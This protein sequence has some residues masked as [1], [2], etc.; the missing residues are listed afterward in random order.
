MNK[1]IRKAFTLIELLVVIAIIGIL[2]GLIVVSMSG[3]TQKANIAKAQVFSSSLRNALMMD[4]VS[5]WK[6][7]GGTIEGT[8]T[9]GDVLDSWSNNNAI[10]V[11]GVPIIKGG[12]DCVSG[13]CIQFNGSTDSIDFGNKAVF[14]MGIKDHTIS[15]WVKFNNNLALQDE[16]LIKTGGGGG[17]AGYW[18]RRP[19]G[20]SALNVG[21]NDGSGEI[22]GYI[23]NSGGLI[24]NSWYN[25]VIIFDR[26]G[27]IKSYVNGQ[28]Q[29][30]SYS[31]AAKTADVSNARTLTLGAY[32][33]DRLAGKMDEVR[34]FHAI[35]QISWIKEQYYIGLNKLLSSGNI[36]ITD[37]QSRLLIIAN[38]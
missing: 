22:N 31:I 20:S 29:S 13:N 35:P 15:L 37:Y 34:I 26:D 23:S 38:K 6:F 1:F 32:T 27:H 16:T 5:E 7:D 12:T 28:I 18:V 9:V 3:V 8:A 24:S 14:S 36:S 4:L 11:I 19:N 21:F 2:S 25:I 33:S 10:T 17:G 30:N